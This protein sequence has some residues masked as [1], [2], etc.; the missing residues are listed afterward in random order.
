VRE[1]AGDHARG[2]VLYRSRVGRIFLR[3]QDFAGV[4]L[5]G[6][7]FFNTVAGMLLWSA[8]MPCSEAERSPPLRQIVARKLSE[9]QP[10]ET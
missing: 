10:S 3:A 4:K 5:P 8:L 7:D 6:A 2:A 1:Q 9:T